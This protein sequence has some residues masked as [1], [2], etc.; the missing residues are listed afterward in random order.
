[1][2]DEKNKLEMLLYKKECEAQDAQRKG[3]KQV[4]SNRLEEI[5]QI[6]RKLSK[7]NM[8]RK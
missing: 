2:S 5:A 6:K 3:M 1:M 4:Y 8:G 7:L